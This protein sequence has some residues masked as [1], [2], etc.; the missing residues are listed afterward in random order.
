MSD[1]VRPTTT[2]PAGAHRTQLRSDA[3]GVP[4][5]LFFV[6][7]AQAPLTSIVGAAV[8][9]IALGNGAGMPGAYLLVGAVIVLFAVGFTTITRTIDSRG[10][11]F[12][13]VK[14]GLGLRVGTGS[15][16]LALLAYNGIQLALYGL[17]GASMSGLVA[18]HFGVDT[19]WWLWVGVTMAVVWLLGTRNIEL[20]AKVLAVLVA[21]EFLLL[22]VFAVGVVGRVGVAG[23]D[24]AASFSPAAVFA[25]APGIA[26]MFAIACMFGFES[27]AIYSAEAKNPQ[28]TIPR[29]TYIA[30]ITIAAF[31]AIVSFML[32]SFYGSTDA[33]GEA[34]KALATDPSGFAVSAITQTLGGWA[35]VLA[36]VLLCSSLFA[37]IL[38]FHNMVTRYFHTMGS[39]G[40]FPAALH[41][42]NTHQAPAIAAT[43]QT[44]LVAVVVGLFAVF[45]QD[46]VGTLFNWFSGMAVVALVV[47]Y[48]LT[49]VAVVVYFRS[50]AT[51]GRTWNTVIAPGVAALLLVAILVAVLNN[52]VLL[53]GG[54]TAVV[55]T[56]LAAVPVAFVL[57]CALTGRNVPARDTAAPDAEMA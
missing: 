8:V 57:G 7:S 5:V 44:A 28:R 39:Q 55:V 16:M 22:I 4:G 24:V 37:G 51:V 53:T 9:A 32:V 13:V 29:A 21:V 25:G 20:G 26:I 42:T 33:Q 23:L 17:Y 31:L 19:S 35:G 27:T 49:S 14:A 56:L 3:V 41:R 12:A 34:L 2:A 52:F 6:L 45:G 47:L 10:G 15:S 1:E 36:D 46:P 40:V 30:V 18:R 11:F 43:A 48:T 38:A 54:S 50:G